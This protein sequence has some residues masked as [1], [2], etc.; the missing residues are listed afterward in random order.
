MMDGQLWSWI[1]T[2]V[3]VTGF[4]LA[5]RRIWWAWYVNLLC[6]ILWFTYA[7]VTTQYGFIA[8]AV[9][10]SVVFTQNAL[11]WTREKNQKDVDQGRRTASSIVQEY[12]ANY[13]RDLDISG[14]IKDEEDQ[15]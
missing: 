6:Q 3:G 10:Y 8:A 5:G 4:I 13:H 2:I 9:V 15:R 11:K 14:A 7:I 12:L 1:L